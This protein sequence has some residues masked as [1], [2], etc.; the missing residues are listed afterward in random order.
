MGGYRAGKS[1]WVEPG[2][3]PVEER[4]GKGLKEGTKEVLL[5]DVGGGLGHDLELLKEE[6]ERLPGRLILQ[7]KEEVLSQIPAT[8]NVFEKITHDFFTPQAVKE[9]VSLSADHN[10]QGYTHKSQVR[11]RT[12]YI[13]S[14]T[15]GM[16]PPASLFSETSSAPWREATRESSSTNW[17]FRIRAQ[18]GPSRAWTG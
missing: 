12:T 10:A 6:H 8:N 18:A 16:T 15:T 3:Y 5:V 17:L 7:D 4:L 1:S 9:F 2:F 11:V 13:P 14:S